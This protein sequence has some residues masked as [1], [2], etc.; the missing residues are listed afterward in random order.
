VVIH[1]GGGPLGNSMEPTVLLDFQMSTLQDQKEN[2]PNWPWDISLYDLA[3]HY[4]IKPDGTIL[5]GRDIGM[6][7]VHVPNLNTGKI[8][9]M[10]MGNFNF[11]EPTFEQVSSALFLVD[12]LDTKY[13][14]DV[15][16]GHGDIGSSDC[17]GKN[18]EYLINL[19]KNS[20]MD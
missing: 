12:Q 6:R 10:L 9:I 3:Y 19:L 5:E 8:G 16:V 17:P 15:V 7:G 20:F 4:I 1:H 14:I 18:S 13:G 11:T 2:D